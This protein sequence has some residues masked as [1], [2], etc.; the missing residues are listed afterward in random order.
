MFF[1][2]IEEISRLRKKKRLL[3]KGMWNIYLKFTIEEKNWCS[4]NFD[5][6]S[7]KNLSPCQFWGA[8]AHSILKL[9]VATRIR[10]LG[11][12]LGGFYFLFIWKGVMAF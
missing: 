3:S 5:F 7:L 11:A 2:P 4:E 8:P 10:G 6:L 12:K 9:L 1:N